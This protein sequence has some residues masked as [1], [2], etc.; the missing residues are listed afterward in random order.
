VAVVLGSATPSLESL[1]NAQAGRYT[2]LR[3]KQRAGAARPPVVRVL[4]VRKRPLRDG[5][6]PEVLAGITQHLHAGH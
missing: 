4:D 1:H 2:H 6:S 5:L 3:L